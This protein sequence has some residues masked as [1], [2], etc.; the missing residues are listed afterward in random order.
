[1]RPVEARYENGMLRPAKTLPLRAG[2]EVAL[3]VI[4]RP[5]AA[6]WDLGRLAASAAEDDDLTN[7]GLE[8]WVAA[9]DAEEAR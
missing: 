3:I 7:L 5:D 9:L 4:R 8:E 2:E 1:M 6:R